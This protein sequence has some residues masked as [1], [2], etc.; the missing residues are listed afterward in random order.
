M[1][2]ATHHKLLHDEPAA[3]DAATLEQHARMAEWMLGVD[4]ERYDALTAGLKALWGIM[5]ALQINHGWR[6]GES[7]TLVQEGMGGYQRTYRDADSVS[8]AAAALRDRYFAGGEGVESAFRFD[9]FD[10]VT[11]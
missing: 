8:R 3:L 5:V 7:E 11:G 4:P 6:R 9:S 1:F 10:S 2:D